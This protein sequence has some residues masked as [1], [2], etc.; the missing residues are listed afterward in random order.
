[1]ML[2]ATPVAVG[3]WHRLRE[4]DIHDQGAADHSG[5]DPSL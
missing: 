2:Q 5:D 1:M 3:F 4:E